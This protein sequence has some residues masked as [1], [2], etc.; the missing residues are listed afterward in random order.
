MSIKLRKANL[1]LKF[2]KK[3]FNQII[4]K[5]NLRVYKKDLKDLK[6]YLDFKEIDPE[7]AIFLFSILSGLLISLIFFSAVNIPLARKNRN[8]KE[9]IKEFN[10][11]KT[12]IPK[13]KSEYENTK[14]KTTD[15]KEKRKF[16]IQLIA[17]TKNLDTFLAVLNNKSTNNQVKV[18]ELEPQKILQFN[19]ISNFN[20]DLSPPS[21]VDT[22][23]ILNN[24]KLLLI[25][26]IEKHVIKIALEGNYIE[27]LSFIRDIELLENIVII[28]DFNI[29]RLTDLEKNKTSK[30]QYTAIISAFGLNK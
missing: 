9:E 12:N 27:I 21:S 3:K 29:K 5:K 18:I 24:N 10:L 23:P 28:G 1:N 30:I 6:T 17:G 20:N 15:L 11:K 7:K 14:I 26:D 22:R 2:I 8:L 16:L 13:V 4:N 19:D 25:P